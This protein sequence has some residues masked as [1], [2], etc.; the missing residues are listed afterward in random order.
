MKVTDIR[1]A[2]QVFTLKDGSTLRVFAR[3]SKEVKDS[4]ISDEILRAEK[5]GIVLLTPSVEVSKPV[6]DEVE[7]KPKKNT[8]GAK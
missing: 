7:V 1:G 8:G 5:M 3:K 2:I 4:L 6:T